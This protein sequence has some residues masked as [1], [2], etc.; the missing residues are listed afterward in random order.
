M[1]LWPVTVETTAR[2]DRVK[3]RR[4]KTRDSAIEIFLRLSGSVDKRKVREEESERRL[5]D[6]DVKLKRRG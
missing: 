4:E 2:R 1:I 5:G 3:A 6:R